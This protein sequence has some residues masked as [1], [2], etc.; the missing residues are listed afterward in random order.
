MRS[1]V[2]VP[3]LFFS[4]RRLLDLQIVHRPIAHGKEALRS[5]QSPL[6]PPP[7]SPLTVKRIS[8]RGSSTRALEIELIDRVD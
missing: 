2:P 7:R 8:K 6:L 3:L 5:P 4:R 1:A